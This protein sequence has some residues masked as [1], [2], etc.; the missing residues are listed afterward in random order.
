VIDRPDEELMAEAGRG[1]EEAMATLI[2]RHQDLVFGTVYRMLSGQVADAEDIAQQVFIK[3][4]R[5]A[6]RYRPDAKFTTW[7]LTICRNCVFTHVKKNRRRAMESLDAPAP[8]GMDEMEV[9]HEDHETLRPDDALLQE[10]MR[11]AV[12]EAVARL[13][14]NQREVLLHRQYHQLEYEEIARVMK[15]SVSSVKSLL[16]RARETLREE[17]KR[18]LHAT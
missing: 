15:I 11:R 13:P 4:Y 6:P 10:E 18:Y 3:V 2:R 7:L 12:E 14:V 9:Q 1:N 17:L 16:F 5:A 8:A